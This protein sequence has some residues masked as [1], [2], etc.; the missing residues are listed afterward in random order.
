LKKKVVSGEQICLLPDG[1]FTKIDGEGLFSFGKWNFK[2]EANVI[3]ASS[4]ENKSA[5]FTVK[6]KTNSK[7]QPSIE[8]TKNGIV[9][10]Y[11]KV[12]DQLASIKNEPYS[13]EN[14]QWRIKPNRLETRNEL[15]TRT[16]GYI[17]HLALLLKST[18]ERKQDIVSFTYT[19]G[20][21]KIYNGGIGIHEYDNLPA[22]WKNIFFNE[23]NALQAYKHYYNYLDTSN[24]AG[25]ATGKWVEDDYNILLSTYA[26]IVNESKR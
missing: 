12:A 7:A 26:D 16:A 15:L 14:N 23:T 10:K 2:Q 3:V 11:T 24:Y 19:K 1:N 17:K 9:L 21:V 8:I 13:F 20:L 5:I 25:A 6:D 4:N 18:Q 22:S